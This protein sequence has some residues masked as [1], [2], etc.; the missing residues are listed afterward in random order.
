M[1][2][3]LQRLDGLISQLLEVGRLDAIGHESE[4]E[5][6]DLKSSLGPLRDGCL[7]PSQA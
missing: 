6:V 2:S 5:D 7:H 1:E 4:P 3:E